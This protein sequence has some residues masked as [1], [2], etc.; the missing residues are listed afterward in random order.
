MSLES[1][2]GSPQELCQIFT[3]T[4]ESFVVSETDR[5]EIWEVRDY[6]EW[7]GAETQDPYDKALGI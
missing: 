5:G 6:Q 2:N 1:S 3:S 7:H 4:N